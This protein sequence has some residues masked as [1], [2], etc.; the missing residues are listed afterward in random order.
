MDKFKYNIRRLENTILSRFDPKMDYPCLH[1]QDQEFRTNLPFQNQRILSGTP[2]FFNSL[3]KLLP[4]I[5]GGAEVIVV[6]TPNL[7]FDPDALGLI[8]SCG[9]EVS[10]LG[11]VGDNYDVVLDC[12]GSFSHLNP[13]LGAVEL[14]HSGESYYRDK[15]C[16]SVDRSEIKLI[17]DV[18]GTSDGLVR[19]LASDG[20]SLNEKNIV[21][22]GFGKVGRGIYLRAN[23]VAK[24]VS[25]IDISTAAITNIKPKDF[26]LFQPGNYTRIQALLADSDVVITATG[27][28]NVLDKIPRPVKR[29]SDQVFVN[30]GAE[31]EFGS[32]YDVTEVFNRKIP[33]NFLLSEP[34][35]LRYLDATFSLHNQSAIDLQQASP[36]VGPR[37]PN[38]ESE[39]QTLAIVKN[40]SSIWKEIVSLNIQ[41]LFSRN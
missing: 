23:A 32:Q 27:Q 26:L 18:L 7:P 8:R 19:A 25:V 28:A 15:N 35:R 5:S 40:S 4:L 38:V 12:I 13:T 39:H 17:E 9:V 24:S 41:S 20:I 29:R 16:I 37:N 11:N 34:T 30:M 14:T 3:P 1:A 22:F 31:D 10:E 36:V 2:I 6:P 33:A 21:V